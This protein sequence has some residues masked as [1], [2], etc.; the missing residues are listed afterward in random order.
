MA[1]IALDKEDILT[2]VFVISLQKYNSVSML[3]KYIAGRYR[4]V[5]V[6]DGPIK[7]RCRFI[8]NAS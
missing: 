2:K 7:A 3:H 4:P 1:L 6:A 5:R 8:K